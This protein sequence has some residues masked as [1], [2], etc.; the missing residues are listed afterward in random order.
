MIIILR[1]ARACTFFLRMNR[2]RR[3]KEK[4]KC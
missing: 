2:I 3:V 1:R 4:A